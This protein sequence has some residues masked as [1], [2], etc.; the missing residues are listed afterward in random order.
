MERRSGGER[1]RASD[2]TFVPLSQGTEVT[3][4]T[5]KFPFES[6]HH[7]VYG[8]RIQSC[9]AM[10]RYRTFCSA[11]SVSGHYQGSVRT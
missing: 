1:V 10:S 5:G 8:E 9:R 7:V 2:T 3:L 11:S 6:S 4:V